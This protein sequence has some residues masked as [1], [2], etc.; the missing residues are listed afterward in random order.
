MSLDKPF[1]AKVFRKIPRP[2]GTALFRG[3]RYNHLRVHK[4]HYRNISL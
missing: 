4:K 3:K 2:A 1:R